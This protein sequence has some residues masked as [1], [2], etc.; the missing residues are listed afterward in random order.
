MM[1]M[2]VT[3]AVIAVLGIIG[4]V[5]LFLGTA[6]PRHRQADL[7][8]GIVAFSLIV[9]VVAGLFIQWPIEFGWQ[10]V[11]AFYAIYGFSAFVFLIY[12]AKGLRLWLTKEEDYYEKK[13]V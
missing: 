2:E 10:E 5:F 13:G 11:T 4:Y 7:F 3:L 8:L 12:A 6:E 9:M 1:K